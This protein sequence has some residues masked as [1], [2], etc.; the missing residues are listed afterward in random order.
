MLM[1]NKFN[2]SSKI[3][4][5]VFL[6]QTSD[7]NLGP[8]NRGPYSVPIPPPPGYV[9]VPGDG[10]RRSGDSALHVQS[11]LQPGGGRPLAAGQTQS[12][13]LRLVQRL[14]SGSVRRDLFLFDD[15]LNVTPAG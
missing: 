12:L 9:G 3:K 7:G 14:G 8:S 11:L 5:K 6:S 4:I 15:C 1:I 2:A 13:Q 10:H